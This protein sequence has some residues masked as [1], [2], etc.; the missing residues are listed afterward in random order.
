[1][2]RGIQV[3]KIVQLADATSGKATSGPVAV[4]PA[5]A[6]VKITL[7]ITTV[8]D[9]ERV[10]IVD[11]LPGGLEPLDPATDTLA[12]ESQNTCDTSVY[13]G[14]NS[15]AYYGWMRWCWQPFGSRQTTPRKI[16]WD[17][18]WI[19][20]GSYEVSYLAVAATQG[21]FVL[22]AGEAF[23]VAMPEVMGTSAVSIVAVEEVDAGLKT[24]KDILARDTA[25]M[26]LDASVAAL[27][28]DGQR[29]LTVKPCAGGCPNGGT[30]NLRTG[31]CQCFMGIIPTAGDCRTMNGEKNPHTE[32]M[33][34]PDDSAWAIAV[35]CALVLIAVIA[36]VA[37]KRIRGR[38]RHCDRSV[39]A[40]AGKEIVSVSVGANGGEERSSSTRTNNE[41]GVGGLE[42]A[43]RGGSEGEKLM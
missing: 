13:R 27:G 26:S 9:L 43:V 32:P 41:A 33:K 16:V 1:M 2:F 14:R 8:D 7:R 20:A 21:L 10:R 28:A 23:S 22:P 5:K 38:A 11:R 36:V 17:S 19:R 31:V 25:S 35:V 30:C 12:A 15:Y 24:L 29:M 40:E 18:R 3:D 34:M 6:F 37:T 42:L 39:K 4:V